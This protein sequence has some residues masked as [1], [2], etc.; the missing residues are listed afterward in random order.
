MKKLKD[1]EYN[2][3]LLHN[4]YNNNKEKKYCNEEEKEEKKEHM[5]LFKIAQKDWENRKQELINGNYIDVKDGNNLQNLMDNNSLN[6]EFNFSFSNTL[7]TD[8]SSMTNLQNLSGYNYTDESE[9]DNY[10]ST[11]N[12]QSEKQFSLSPEFSLSTF[13]FDNIDNLE[14]LDP[15]LMN[16]DID[17][18]M[19]LLDI[20]LSKNNIAETI[21]ESINNNTNENGNN[22]PNYLD[23]DITKIIQEMSSKS[24][25]SLNNNI[26]ENNSNISLDEL[27]TLSNISNSESNITNII[28]ELN[29]TILPIINDTLIPF[30]SNE[31]SSNNND[32]NSDNINN[33]NND[34]NDNDNNKNI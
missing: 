18:D 23:T 1:E 17:F 7:T 33:N 29:P 25:P 14:A 26:L 22:N 3:N 19:N 8:D 4:K 28:N 5:K 27:P 10:D 32:D 15:N 12:F 31:M 16:L 11:N 34:D 21:T 13:N 6:N 24:I 9:K 30:Q 2:L 20:D